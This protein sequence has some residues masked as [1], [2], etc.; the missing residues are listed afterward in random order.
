M[1]L[2]NRRVAVTLV[3]TDKSD[4]SS[5][6]PMPIQQIG[7]TIVETAEGVGSVIITVAASLTA[8]RITETVIRHILR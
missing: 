4:D 8:L 5:M 6:E 7:S 1:L 3:K 2:R